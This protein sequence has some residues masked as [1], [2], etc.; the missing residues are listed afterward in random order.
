MY[1]MWN[2]HQVHLFHA[3]SQGQIEEILRLMPA[4]SL[5]AGDYLYRVGDTADASFILRTGIVKLFHIT[6][7]GREQIIDIA[8]RGDMFGDPFLRNAQLRPLSAQALCDVAVRRLHNDTLAQLL[9]RFPELAANLISYMAYAEY[10]M[11]RRLQ[12]LMQPLPEDRLLG[13]LYSLV[14]ANTKLADLEPWAVLPETITQE[15]IANM[16]ALNRSTVSML[17]NRFRREGLLGGQ[18]R[19][20][21]VNTADLRKRLQA[22]GL[23]VDEREAFSRKPVIS[24]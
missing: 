22:V 15:A 17:I 11:I 23:E 3:L 4:Q 16:V 12:L 9:R 18:G 24:L 13:V 5:R 8:Q 21:S 19:T 20:V 6:S 14:R 10:Q 2:W 7:T 1:E